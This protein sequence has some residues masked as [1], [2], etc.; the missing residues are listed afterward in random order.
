M[1]P[2]GTESDALPP[3]APSA[4]PSS[5]ERYASIV[6]NAIEGIF[7]STPD[8]QYLLVNPALAK[9]YGYESPAELM[10]NVQDISRTIY[11]D[12]SV[13]DVFKRLMAR[14]GEVRGLEYQVRRKDGGIIWISEHA[15]TVRDEEGRVLYYEGFV[16]DITRRKEAEEELR[17]AKE[18]A[19]TASRAKS[20]FLAVMSHEIRTPMNGVIGMASLLLDSPLSPEQHDYAETIRHSGDALLTLINDILDFSKIESGRLELEHEEFVLRECVEGALD[21]LA[22]RAGEKQID[23]LY[24]I[25]EGAP[26]M[27]RGDSTRLRQ[28]LVNLLGNAVKFTEQGEVVLTLR[29]EALPATGPGRPES[30]RLLFA[31]RDTGI[32]IPPEAVGRLFQSFSQVDASTTRRYGGTGLGLVISQ[33]LAEQMGGTMSVESEPGRGSTFRFSAVVETGPNKPL[34]YRV[35]PRAVLGGKHLLLVDDN[36][37]NLRI[38]TKFAQN[39]EIVPRTAASGAEALALI[40]AGATFDFAILDMQMPAMDGAM[41]AREIRRRRPT[42][43]LPIVLLTSLGQRDLAGNRSLFDVSLTKPAKPG[44]ILD[45]LVRVLTRGQGMASRARHSAP[46]IAD[47][48]VHR[49]RVLL[50]EDNVVNQKVALRMLERLNYRADLAANGVEVLEAMGR[51]AYDIIIMDVHMPEMDGLEATRRLRANPPAGGHRPWIVA[52]TANAIQGDREMCLAAGMDDYVSKPIKTPEL[53]AA[54]ARAR[55]ALA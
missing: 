43:Q 29:T 24:E 38:L 37:T 5:I 26:V 34:P 36:P 12:A 53:A 33:R 23:L 41:L 13:R 8:G 27:V 17:A 25:S 2:S 18:A 40:D 47:Q 19:E 42:E 16:Q 7:Q 22:P 32:G 20:Q 39:W 35:S 31:V 4:W 10:A 11:V 50:A 45:A 3:A 55:A 15:R 48:T 49:E 44:Q 30:T 1:N 28:I 21:L 52:L 14:D 51:Q 46:P 9:L 6:Q 54:L